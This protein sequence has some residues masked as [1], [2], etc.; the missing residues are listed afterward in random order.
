VFTSVVLVYPG[1]VEEGSFHE[2]LSKVRDPLWCD[3]LPPGGW[4]WG[5]FFYV[6]CYRC[7]LLIRQMETVAL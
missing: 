1:Q 2:M 5:G 6:F 3:A 7:S 4:F